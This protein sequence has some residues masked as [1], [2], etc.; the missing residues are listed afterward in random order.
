[1]GC[2]FAL[3]PGKGPAILSHSVCILTG[4]PHKRVILDW[5]CICWEHSACFFERSVKIYY[6][7]CT[8]WRW[9]VSH[10]I[11]KTKYFLGKLLGNYLGKSLWSCLKGVE[12]NWKKNISSP[13]WWNHLGICNIWHI[14][15]VLRSP[16]VLG[17]R[18][19]N[20]PPVKI[21]FLLKEHGVDIKSC[22]IHIFFVFHHKMYWCFTSIL[23][24]HC[25]NWQTESYTSEYHVKFSSTWYLE[26]WCCISHSTSAAIASNGLYWSP[27]ACG[28]ICLMVFILLILIATLNF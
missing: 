13:I 9:S 23:L 16:N 19:E 12:K 18:Y 26:V 3:E 28:W 11:F 14:Y 24:P 6:T 22:F 15:S 1:M 5:Y 7:T 8:A 2:S 17:N 20:L 10:L 25:H 21:P 4:N 27:V